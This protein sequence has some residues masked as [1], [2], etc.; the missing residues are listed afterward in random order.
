MNNTNFSK[1][2]KRAFP[3][4]K[5]GQGRVGARR[6]AIYQGIAV[7]EGSE[8]ATETIENCQQWQQWQ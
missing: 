5:K 1:E 4:V 8:V 7:K 6:V 3:D 2:I